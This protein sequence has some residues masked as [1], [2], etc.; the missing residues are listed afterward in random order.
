MHLGETPAVPSQKERDE[1]LCRNMVR[2]TLYNHPK[3]RNE[4]KMTYF[5]MTV[6]KHLVLIYE[7]YCW[8]RQ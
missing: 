4:S 6:V 5:A 1:S 7:K 3:P 2:G 8:R